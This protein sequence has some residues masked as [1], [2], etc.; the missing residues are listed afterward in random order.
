MRIIQLF[1]WFPKLKE[2]SDELT[3]D[4]AL[5]DKFS[6]LELQCTDQDQNFNS[7]NIDDIIF[8]KIRLHKK[9]RLVKGVKKVG[10]FTCGFPEELSFIP[11]SELFHVM[12][13]NEVFVLV[14]VLKPLDFWFSDMCKCLRAIVPKVRSVDWKIRQM[15]RPLEVPLYDLECVQEDLHFKTIVNESN[16]E[17]MVVIK[18]RVVT[19]EQLEIQTKLKLVKMEYF[20]P[21]VLLKNE[22]LFIQSSNNQSFITIVVNEQCK[23]LSSS[24]VLR[25]LKVE[26][27]KSME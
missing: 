8:I 1:E 14:K 4:L 19:P 5:T 15:P 18:V 17:Q 13:K 12:P 21:H 27:I 25:H 24:D 2:S 10:I 23:H 3:D 6:R 26:L 16:P 22:I 20:H 11:H 7:F 9:Y